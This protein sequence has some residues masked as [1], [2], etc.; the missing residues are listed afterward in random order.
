[1][2]GVPLFVLR[3]LR[4]NVRLHL[5]QVEA[6]GRHRIPKFLSLP[7]NSRAMAM[8]LFPLRNPTME[9][10]AYFGGISTQIC[11]WSGSKWPWTIR[12][13]FCRANSWKI[14][15]SLCRRF[16]TRSRN[17]RRCRYGPAAHCGA[18]RLSAGAARDPHRSDRGSTRGVMRSDGRHCAAFVIRCKL[19]S[20][21]L[22]GA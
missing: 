8:A 15:P 13:S 4:A 1:M 12:H 7:A 6:Y 17:L 19:R 9:A 2:L 22:P 20:S 18:G 3:F 10:T 14:G 21:V 11:T 5:L 16:P